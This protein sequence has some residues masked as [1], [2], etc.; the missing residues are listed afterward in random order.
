MPDIVFELTIDAEPARVSDAIASEAGIRGWWTDSAEVP[1]GTGGVIRLGFAMAPAPFELRVD[2]VGE[3][4]VRWASVGN[5][6]PHWAGTELRWAL[7]PAPEG[8]G[9]TVS[10][11]HAGWPSDEGMFGMTAFTWGQ[12]MLSLKA[13]VETGSTDLRLPSA[14]IG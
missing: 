12:L 10:F 1:D 2:E 5:F 11:R 13:Y 4:A 6:P 7:A 14:P 8:G 9:T 3:Q